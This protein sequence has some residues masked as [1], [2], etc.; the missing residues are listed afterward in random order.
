MQ[1]S[2]SARFASLPTA[3]VLERVRQTLPT[4]VIAA[5]SLPKSSFTSEPL[6]V[7]L[8]TNVLLDL[9]Y[10]KDKD[11]GLLKQQLDCGELK[12]V[13]SINCLEEFADVISRAA[14]ALKADAQIAMLQEH[15]STALICSRIEPAPCRCRDPDDQ[16]FLD[17]AF[18]AKAKVLFTKDKLVRKAAKKLARY[19]IHTLMPSE[20]RS[21]DAVLRT[22]KE[23]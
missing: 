8:D 21:M 23:P 15:V 5:P 17:L 19:G 12:A 14:F 9:V 16:K 7:V 3:Q 6:L 18:S 11:S 20:W 13:T 1:A 4:S 10:W 22:A 2:A